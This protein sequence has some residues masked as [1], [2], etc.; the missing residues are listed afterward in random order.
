MS[1]IFASA[2][3]ILLIVSVFN[4]FSRLSNPVFNN[5][6]KKEIK[7]LI[8]NILIVGLIGCVLSWLLFYLWEY[9][10]TSCP[11]IVLLLIILG[12]VGCFLV[13]LFL[14][15]VSPSESAIKN[16]ENID[17]SKKILD[18]FLTQYSVDKTLKV[19]DTNFAICQK[20]NVLLIYDSLSMLN[21]NLKYQAIPFNSIIEC[22]I[23]EDNSTIMKSGLNRAIVGAA[24][25]GTTGAIVGVATRKTSDV[26]N[27]LSIRIITNEVLNPHHEIKII[28]ETINRNS[29]EYKQL[30]DN[31]QE[32]YSSVIAIIQSNK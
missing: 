9:E 11:F 3:T 17:K 10:A 12:S 6:R 13:V 25:A 24:I 31:V 21:N 15:A 20:D 29:D 22:E 4:L 23:I 30:Y 7:N 2:F 28:T 27:N 16:K 19:K 8:R 18:E 14:W 5:E 26:V 1:F 32:I